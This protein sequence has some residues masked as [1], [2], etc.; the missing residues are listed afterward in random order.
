[1][2]ETLARSIAARSWR[3]L[4]CLSVAAVL[5]FAFAPAAS[6]RSA[7]D[8]RS[9]AAGYVPSDSLYHDY[10]EMVKHIHA[11]AAAHPDIVKLFSIG[12]S[13]KGRTLWAAKISDNVNVDENEPEVLFDGLHHA[14]E[15]L[16]AEMTISLLDLLAGKYG[17][18]SALAKRVTADVNSREIYIIFM[19]NPDGLEYDLSRNPYRQ[20]RKNRQPTPGT[21]AIGTDINRNYGYAWGLA[22]AGADNNPRSDTYQGPAAWSTPEAR[23]VRD[24]VLSR[25]VGGVQQIRTHITFHS[26]AEEILWPYGHTTTAV[27]PDMTKLD[28]KALAAMGKQMATMNGYRP[29]QSSAFYPTSGDEIDW[30]YGTQRIFSY[31]F[32]MYPGNNDYPL[33]WNGPRWYVPDNLIARETKRN[34][35]PSLYLI[36]QADCPYR[37]I[38]MAAEYCGPFFD[39]LEISR[40]WTVATTGAGLATSGTW[41]RGIA[42]ASTYQLPAFSGQGELVTGLGGADVDGGSTKVRSR[43]ITLPAAAT[44]LQLHYWTGMDSRATASD[45]LTVRLVSASGKVLATALTVNGNGSKQLP[46]WK[47]L[48]YQIPASLNGRTVFIQ[49]V[50]T[51][52]GTDAT[53]K[54][55]VDDVRITVR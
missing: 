26:A 5:L 37:A 12:K 22:S 27:P 10:P 6:A 25:V 48:D 55:G 41:V 16:S 2:R 7:H 54:A 44:D 30:M 52:A 43:A 28:H 20:W 21:N 11:V 53:V 51:D 13:Y 42:K 1:M 33:P 39:D 47:S 17:G 35:K 18:T 45:G 19:V 15:H 38:G 40:G 36:E 34:W 49:L 23:A 3:G 46:V 9:N 50:A 31:T 8:A 32:E 24:F 29:M 14:R 4:A